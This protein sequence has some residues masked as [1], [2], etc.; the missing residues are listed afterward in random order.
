MSTLKRDRIMLK[1][2]VESYGKKDVLNFVRH[3]NESESIDRYDFLDYDNSYDVFNG[4]GSDKLMDLFEKYNYEISVIANIPE[5]LNILKR[6]YPGFRII[7]NSHK[8]AIVL[9]NPDDDTLA[10]GYIDDEWNEYAVE[11]LPF[12]ESRVSIK[13]ANRCWDLYKQEYLATLP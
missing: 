4:N 6:R 10:P 12:G 7:N 3:L 11:L 9:W 5:L 2:L 1:R 13:E 8:W